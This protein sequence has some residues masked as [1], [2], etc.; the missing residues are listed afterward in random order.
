IRPLAILLAGWC[1]LTAV[2]FHT[3]FANL[4]ALMNFFK[5]CTMAGGFLLIAKTHP[6]AFSIDKYLAH[7]RSS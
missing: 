6:A 1:L 3:Q 7:H 2:I 5:N 4:D